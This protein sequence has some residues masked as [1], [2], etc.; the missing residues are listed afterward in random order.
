MIVLMGKSC[1]GKDTIA[2]VLLDKYG[3]KRPLSYTTRA[4]RAGEADGKDYH[5]TTEEE[6]RSKIDSDFFAEWKSYDVDGQTLYYGTAK[7]AFLNA[8]DK[9][10][11]ILTPAGIIDLRN[12]GY[13]LTV[14]YVT[15]PDDVALEHAKVRGD[16]PVAV[17]DRIE[18]DAFD[19]IGAD[20]LADYTVCNDGTLPPD[21]I[22][23]CIAEN[24]CGN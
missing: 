12:E 11:M 10:L 9:S 18:K 16:N 17:Q 3:F 21:E 24:V 15:A 13:D 19:F 4:P 23:R 6:F 5:F 2:K 20:L 1:R 22:A 8:T 7:S 14:V